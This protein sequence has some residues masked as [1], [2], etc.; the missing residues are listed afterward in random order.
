MSFGGW[1]SSLRSSTHPRPVR[2]NR[3]M[4][5]SVATSTLRGLLLG[6]RRQVVCRILI[7]EPVRFQQEADV[8]RRHDRVV[9]RPRNVCVPEG[10]PK[11]DVGVFDRAVSLGPADQA[12]AAG[13]LVRMVARGVH[14]FLLE[15]RDPDVVV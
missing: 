8:R 13:T 15:G 4:D 2:R 7:E 5:Y 10:V 11:Q 9:L 1:A 12:I 3:T 6:R 14:L